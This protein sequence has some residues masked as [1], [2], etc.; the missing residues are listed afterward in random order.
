VSKLKSL[1][2]QARTPLP[3]GLRRAYAAFEDLMQSQ[4]K[5]AAA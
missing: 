1:G 3:D 4:Q 2:W 5:R